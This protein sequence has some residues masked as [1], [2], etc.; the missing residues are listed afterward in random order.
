MR[1][2]NEKVWSPKWVNEEFNFWHS[3]LKVL[4]L[5]WSLRHN[6]F[7]MVTSIFSFSS[8]FGPPAPVWGFPSQ[9]PFCGVQKSLNYI[10][11]HHL[12]HSTLSSLLRINI[13]LPQA[14]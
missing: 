11:S 9:T 12:K 14:R 2:L 8:A 7:L 6:G 1:S 13:T 10:M 4:Q 3:L 5:K